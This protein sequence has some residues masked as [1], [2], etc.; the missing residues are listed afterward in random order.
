[1]ITQKFWDEGINDSF[2]R[3]LQN[4]THSRAKN[5]HEDSHIWPIWCK[6]TQKPL[7]WSKW[8][9]ARKCK[10][11]LPDC[12][13]SVLPNQAFLEKVIKR[14]LW[15]SVKSLYLYQFSKTWHRSSCIYKIY[16]YKLWKNEF[17]FTESPERR[18]N[19]AIWAL[20]G[21]LQLENHLTWKYKIF[22]DSR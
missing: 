21:A 13:N 2:Q 14:Y 17:V 15:T 16:P 7:V 6:I 1:M 12:G 5:T 8:N 18:Q 10:T 9:F 3:S 11:I 20:F 22:S 4:L 19:M